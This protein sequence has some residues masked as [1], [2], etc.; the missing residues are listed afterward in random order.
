MYCI[1]QCSQLFL[2]KHN[3]FSSKFCGLLTSKTLEWLFSV[4]LFVCCL[5]LL[6]RLFCILCW[7]LLWRYI[8]FPCPCVSG[9]LSPC[10]VQNGGCGDL[11]LLTPDGTVNC[12]CRG[13]RILLD[14]NRCVCKF[15][16]ASLRLSGNM[17][18]SISERCEITLLHLFQHL[19]FICYGHEWY[20][21][22]CSFL[23]KCVL[24]DKRHDS[25]FGLFFYFIQN[26]KSIK[27]TVE[28]IFSMINIKF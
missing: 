21:E 3:C 20:F 23:T 15:H 10:R 17:S 9:E 22:K 2:R 25:N 8:K 27:N 6:F 1:C 16:H 4:F 13:G 11:C 26:S 18:P 12:S 28:Y 19:F 14:D 5:I 24:L 7:A